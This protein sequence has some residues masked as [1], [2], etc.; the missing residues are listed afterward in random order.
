[1]AWMVEDMSL[2]PQIEGQG[3]YKT[4]LQEPQ[5]ECLEHDA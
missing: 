4:F 3:L 2:D 5:F 1:M